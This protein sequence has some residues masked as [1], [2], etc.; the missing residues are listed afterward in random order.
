M[1]S[2]YIWYLFA[3]ALGASFL[4]SGMEAGV[5]AL[6][7][8]RIRRLARSGQKSAKL[9]NRFL[10]KPERF[11]WTILV[12]N[13]LANF[14]I[15][16]WLL[17]KLYSWF[18]DYPWHRWIIVGS[19]VVVVFFFYVFFDLLPK[20]LFMAHPNS[21]CLSAAR[22][23]RI[24]NFLLGPLVVLVDEISQAILR[25]T[26]GRAFTGRVFGNREELRAVMQESG[27]VLSDDEHAMVNR[28]LDLQNYTVGQ[29][30]RPMAEVSGIEAD[31]PVSAAIAIA[32][33]KNFSRLPVWE[34]RE[35]RR[36]VA[37]LLEIGPLLY[38][39]SLDTGRPASAHMIPALFVD[40]SLRL[41]IALR[42]MQRSGQP[43][44]IVLSRDRS[45]VGIVTVKDILKLMFGEM[46]L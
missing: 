27:G 8:L 4:F 22:I 34:N 43:M 31:K 1:D 39:E 35:G 10:E 32:G 26:G 33:E 19:Y 20:M 45:E 11:L 15:M 13:T 3:L 17:V 14:F 29:I 9:L 44:G 36:R 23:F 12:G 24:I 18:L 30:A 46:K 42:L 41:E 38:R 37:G 2:S 6:N 7:R 40:E 16:G 21:L 5:F 25:W 28:I